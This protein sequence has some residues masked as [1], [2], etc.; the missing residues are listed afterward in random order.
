M[1]NPFRYIAYLILSRF[2]KEVREEYETVI[3]KGKRES[4]KKIAGLEARLTVKAQNGRRMDIT[5]KVLDELKVGGEV[6]MVYKKTIQTTYEVT[7]DDFKEKQKVPGSERSL[8]YTPDYV[9]GVQK[10]S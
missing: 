10:K 7:Y 5:A 8:G 6:I 9:Y 4:C 1:K 2:F 3:V